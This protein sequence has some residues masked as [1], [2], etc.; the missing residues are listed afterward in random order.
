MGYI[1]D[2]QDA[3]E[4]AR[5][6]ALDYNQY[7]VELEHHLMINLLRPS[8]GES[9][10]DIGCGAGFSSQPLLET[11]LDVTGIDPSPYMLDFAFKR[12]QERVDLFRGHAEDL[13][14]DD[15]SF[16]YAVFFIS[17]EF[18]EDPL[19]A[20]EEACR[21]AKD[22]VFFGLLNRFALRG[23]QRWRKGCYGPKVF[24]YAHF[25]NLWKLKK[26]VHSVVG[27]VPVTWRTVCQF[28]QNQTR[29]AQHFERSNI[30]QRC[31]FG[32]FVG[33]AATL[34]PR[35]RTRPLAIRY[36]PKKAPR[37]IPGSVRV[38]SAAMVD[39]KSAGRLRRSDDNPPIAGAEN[40]GL[41]L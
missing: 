11:G 15:N 2:F 7:A 35:F 36:T 17:L 8:P 21:V 38:G 28:P 32:A 3:R 30:V 20:V 25:F 18:V 13:P 41:S 40:A 31:P 37:V 26:M 39:R 22:K 14:F 1:F 34:V 5:W 9:V 27:D 19:R 12:F 10:L 4:Y 33:M 16:N 23:A 29:M 6:A 24:E